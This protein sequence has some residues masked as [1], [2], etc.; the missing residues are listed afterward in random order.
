MEDN[1]RNLLIILSGIVIAAIFIHGLWTIRKKRNP[2]KLKASKNKVQP[3]SRGFDGKGFD[4]DG[5]GQ[6]KVLKQANEPEVSSEQDFKQS[7]SLDE[8]SHL[9]GG[10][11]DEVYSE[12]ISQEQ[13][14]EHDV[15]PAEYISQEKPTA[16]TDAKEEI[17]LEKQLYQQPVI[18]AKPATKKVINKKAKIKAEIKHG[19]TKRPQREI[20]FGDGLALD[21]ESM[22]S[23][24]IDQSI[25]QAQEHKKISNPTLETQ[26]I[27]LSVVMPAHQ[28]MSGA[29]LL[30]SLLTLGMK[31][32]EMNI[33]H[34][35]QDNA[36][37]G[38]VTFSLA[39]MFL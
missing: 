37:N 38:A 3:L 6:V 29:V 19:A 30:P 2:Y 10:Q 18:Q 23:I 35:H 36:G 11:R 26:V 28:Q 34:R 5:V 31:Y 14:S 39:N 33:F 9:D 8:I 32:G 27:I 13:I 22:P 4:Q 20:N 12:L 15:E 16:I 7:I 24:N 21:N 17:I 1:F 25:E